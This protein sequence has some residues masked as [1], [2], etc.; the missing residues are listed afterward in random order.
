[1]TLP[2]KV[3][4]TMKPKG[5]AM[6]GQ[7]QDDTIIIPY[8]TAQ[9]TLMGITCLDVIPCSSVA[10]EVIKLAGRQPRALLRDRPLLRAEQDD[11]FNIRNPEDI[12][13]AQLEA[14]RTL[15]LLLI[16]I[17]STSLIGG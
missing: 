15:T 3:V 16:A 10:Q 11:D 13:Q 7:D 6:S 9:K 5:L 17:P 14:S 8:T 2:M 1:K 4:A 12:I